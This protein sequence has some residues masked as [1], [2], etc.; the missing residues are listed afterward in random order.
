MIIAK[1]S[2]PHIVARGKLFCGPIPRSIWR[3]RLPR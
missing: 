1:L 3:V 2:D